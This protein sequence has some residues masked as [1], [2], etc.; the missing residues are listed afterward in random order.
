MLQ[1][2]EENGVIID[3]TRKIIVHIKEKEQETWENVVEKDSKSNQ[4]LSYKV[5]K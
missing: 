2:E 1:E 5:L 3:T 4:K